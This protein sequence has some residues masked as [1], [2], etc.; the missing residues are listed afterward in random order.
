MIAWD[1]VGAD[2]DLNVTD[3]NGE[4]IE[5]GRVSASGL[6]KVRDCPGR[7]RACGG[8]NVENVFLEGTKAPT[9]GSYRVSV[10]LESLQ[11]EAAPVWVNLSC[12]LGAQ[13]VAFE[14]ELFRPEDERSVDLTL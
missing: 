1:A 14:I 3:P 10:R 13:R 4:L 5:V 9:P 8:V 12:R 2:V 11:G 7:Q 6:L